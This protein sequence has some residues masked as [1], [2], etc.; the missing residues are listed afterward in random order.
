MAEFDITLV[1]LIE[2]RPQS[3]AVQFGRKRVDVI[4]IERVTRRTESVGKQKHADS[5]TGQ[6][7][8]E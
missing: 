8:T 5:D 4:G 6:P 3:N 2:H 1:L 7:Y